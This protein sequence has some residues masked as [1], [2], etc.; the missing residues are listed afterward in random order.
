MAVADAQ[1]PL[2][3]AVDEEQSAERPERLPAQR[4]GAFLIEQDHLASC[5][6]Q[7]GGGDEARKPPADDDHIRVH[8]VLPRYRPLPTEVG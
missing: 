4:L 5:V 6:R 1:A 7:L 8:V 2:L 3:G